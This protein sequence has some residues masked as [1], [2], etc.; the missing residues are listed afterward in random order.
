MRIRIRQGWEL[1]ESR[2]TPESVVMARRA[3]LG[4]GAGLVLNLLN[5]SNAAVDLTGWNMQYA[6]ANGYPMARSYVPKCKC[7]AKAFQHGYPPVN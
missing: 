7:G 4:A 2:A 5:R 3:L 1:P 6:D